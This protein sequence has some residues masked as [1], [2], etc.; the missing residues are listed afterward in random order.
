MKKGILSLCLTIMIS[1]LSVSQSKA[2]ITFT[3]TFGDTWYCWGNGTRCTFSIDI[4]KANIQN[5][6]NLI[7]SIPAG[8]NLVVVK[9]ASWDAKTFEGLQLLPQTT[10]PNNVSKA[11][12]TMYFPSQKVIYSEKD[13]GYLMYF[14]KK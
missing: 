13:G 10:I 9:S 4:L 1:L 8:A 14:F 12:Y 6:T 7:S 3:T 2:G 5:Y 11:G